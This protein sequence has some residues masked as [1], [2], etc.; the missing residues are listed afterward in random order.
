GRDG[1]PVLVDGQRHAVDRDG[2][3]FVQKSPAKDP[4]DV[5]GLQERCHEAC[6][7]LSEAERGLSSY[8]WQDTQRSGLT[9]SRTGMSTEQCGMAN[10]QRGWNIQPG[11]GDSKDGDSRGMPRQPSV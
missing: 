10:G 9:S 2:V 6:T 5:L 11:G 8:R 7:P 1:R 3:A 4:R